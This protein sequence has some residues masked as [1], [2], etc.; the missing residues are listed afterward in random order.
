G[1]RDLWFAVGLPLFLST[2][3]DW[4]HAEVGGYMA[5]WVIAYGFVQAGA[6]KVLK[7]SGDAPGGALSRR[8][9]LVLAFVTG[10]IALAVGAEVAPGLSVIFGLLVFGFVFAVNSAVHSY[11]V[12]AYSKAQHVSMDVGFYYMANAGGRLVGTILSGVMYQWGG[13]AVCLA[14]STAFVV[15]AWAL[16]TLLPEPSAHD[17]SARSPT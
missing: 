9:L 2:T 8:W 4:G 1:S 3:L 6:P 12:L 15:A 10:A 5:A 7:R 14:V 11:L 13:L 17:P 16:S